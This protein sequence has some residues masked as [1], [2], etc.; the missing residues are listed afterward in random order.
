MNE[1]MSFIKSL[2]DSFQ[3]IKVDHQQQQQQ[4]FTAESSPT[5]NHL[6]PSSQQ[7][8]LHNMAHKIRSGH[9]I[10]SH[11]YL[12]GGPHYENYLVE[13]SAGEVA[14]SKTHCMQMVE[15]L[16]SKLHSEHGLEMK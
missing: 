8:L 11:D 7:Y 16:Q 4:P 9:Q 2:E 15:P 6:N 10:K 1:N 5:H 12:V 3:F 13:D 14:N